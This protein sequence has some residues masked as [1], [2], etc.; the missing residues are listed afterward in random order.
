MQQITLE[1]ALVAVGIVFAVATMVERGIELVR[2]LL[3]KIKN[4]SWLKSAKVGAAVI[5]GFVL[6]YFLKLDA[7]SAFGFSLPPIA[8]YA[9]TAA[10]ASAG[11]SPWHALLEWLKTIKQPSIIATAEL[12]EALQKQA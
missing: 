2:P 11:A 6:C 9:V 1:M 4:E 7:M 12:S 5:V 3:E 8:G 10:L